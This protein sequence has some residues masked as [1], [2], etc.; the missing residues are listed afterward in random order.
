MSAREKTDPGSAQSAPDSVM[1]ELL[2]PAVLDRESVGGWE[3]WRV[4]RHR[5]FEPA[6]RVDLAAWRSMSPRDRAAYDLHRIATHAN[7]PFLETPMSAAVIAVMWARL[8]MNAVKRKPTTRAGLMINGGGYQ[9]KTE[10][11]CE[12]AALFADTWLT[13]HEANPNAVPGTR[14]LHA[15]VAY[16]QTPVTAKPKS[17]CQAILDFYGADHKGMT[18]PQLV[19]A[20]RASLRDHATKVLILDDI[21]R[22]R[23]HREAD[24]DVLDLLRALM[25]MDLTLV[26]VGV[27]IPVSGLL[28]E[29]RQDPRT[30]A[31]TFTGT[32][33]GGFADEAATQTERRFD[34]LELGPFRYD[35]GQDIDAWVSHLAGIEQHLR[36]LQPSA[37]M[38][39]GGSMP[40]YLFRRTGGIVGLLE[41]LIE[42][43]CTHAM[44]SGRE[45]LDVVGLDQVGLSL[46]T[47]P[48]RDP[49]AGEVPAL[50][51][52]RPAPPRRSATPATGRP[53]HQGRNKVFDDHAGTRSTSCPPVRSRGEAP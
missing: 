47:A 37:G 8:R 50:A 45:R 29:G 1:V 20:V 38:L 30:G 32:G 26:L 44:D 39:T 22:L 14:D 12:V 4:G 10:T 17:V 13:L 35:T 31:W 15:P 46:A 48:G 42:D 9:G 7:L 28:R 36:L 23:M 51:A 27:G 41:R 33:R 5:R 6:P 25:S 2:G 43:G 11:V 3:A 53:R 19:G 34:L 49:S 21:T 16:V 18:L 52:S 40:E 24:Q